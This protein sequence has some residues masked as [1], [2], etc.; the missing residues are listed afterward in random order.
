[1][2][3][4]VAVL[5]EIFGIDAPPPF[6]SEWEFEGGALRLVRRLVA[7]FEGSLLTDPPYQPLDVIV[8]RSPGLERHLWLVG[9]MP[10]TLWHA[11]P[12]GVARTGIGEIERLDHGVLAAFEP[13]LEIRP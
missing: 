13:T 9:P 12:A 1:M 3:F 2:G 11:G 10:D 7:R 4:V 8:S 6:E 5:D